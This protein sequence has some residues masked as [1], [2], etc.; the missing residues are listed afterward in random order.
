MDSY[1]AYRSPPEHTKPQESRWGREDEAYQRRVTGKWGTV[2][3]L[4]AQ[5]ACLASTLP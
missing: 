3:S 5:N 2:K 4:L 1:P